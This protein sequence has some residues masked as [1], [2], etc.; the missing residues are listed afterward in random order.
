V[1]AAAVP[2]D[3]AH[4][5]M[6]FNLTYPNEA[7]LT[8]NPAATYDGFYL[9]AYAVFAS[10]G[11]P[12]TGPRIADA[13]GR[14]HAPGRAVATGPSDLFA[15]ITALANG[16]AIDPHGP[17]GAL[18]FDTA[19]G[20]RSVDFA[21]LCAGIDREGRASGDVE[22]GLVFDAKTRSVRGTMRCP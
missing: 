21:L 14:L 22:S 16:D 15:A 12:V 11:G 20:E 9:V 17:S 1:S 3:E 19:T 6:R 5:V 18:D 8:I 7:T 2:V 13:L 10:R 4:F